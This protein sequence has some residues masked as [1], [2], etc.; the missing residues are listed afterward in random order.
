MRSPKALALGI[1]LAVLA[2]F[3]L[4]VNAPRLQRAYHDRQLRRMSLARL[5]SFVRAHPGDLDARYRLGLA[6]AREDRF[7]EATRELLAVVQ[8]DP[9]RA[10][11]WND[12]GVAYLLQQRYYE[13]LLALQSALA[14]DPR[15]A[16]AHG[17][18]GRLHLATQMPF[19]ATPELERA[20]RLAPDDPRL[21]CDLGEA[22]QQTLNMKSAEAVYRQ[23]LRRDPRNL[24]ARRGLGRAYFGLADYARAEQ[25]LAQALVLA[26]EDAATLH[27][28][29]RLRLERAVSPV[30]LDEARGLL[31]RA[32]KGDPEDPEIW[33]ELAKVRLRLEKPEAA[34]S[35]LERALTLSPQHPGAMYLRGRALRAAGRTAQAERAEIVFRRMSLR[36]R[37]ETMLEER[38]QGNPRDWDARARLTELYL[39]SRKV[40]L[41]ALVY[42]QLQDGAPNHPR[43]PVLR[44][45]LELQR[46]GA[47]AAPVGGS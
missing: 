15:F 20:A 16:P 24:D 42:R 32:A 40:G 37:E 1:A 39:L 46:G 31:E 2:A 22:Y 19:T 44:R 5:E 7:L 25:A 8:Q 23:A 12:L 33:Y 17:N 14:A 34:L 27:A 45:Q 29:G 10:A 6:Y 47:A 18:M 21:L 28:L 41:A 4:G 3:A 35:A 11:A 38:L 9:S 30:E 13:S 36:L 26:P 43:L